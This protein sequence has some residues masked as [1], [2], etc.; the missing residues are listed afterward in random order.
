[1]S[2]FGGMIMEGIKVTMGPNSLAQTKLMFIHLDI[3]IFDISLNHGCYF[4]ELAISIIDFPHKWGPSKRKITT[5]QINN[6]WKA[7][8]RLIKEGFAANLDLARSISN[9]YHD[10]VKYCV[11][12]ITE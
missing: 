2:Q 1:M 12:L 9:V 8:K 11:S 6:V 5:I 7:M 3:F 10:F 4:C